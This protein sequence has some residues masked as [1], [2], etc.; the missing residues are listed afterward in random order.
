VKAL[1]GAHWLGGE[2]DSPMRPKTARHVVASGA[3][4][5]GMAGQTVPPSQAAPQMKTSDWI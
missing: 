5:V 2:R 4:D 3:V 1:A